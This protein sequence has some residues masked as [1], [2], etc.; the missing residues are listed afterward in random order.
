MATR[1]ILTLN[2]LDEYL[3]KIAQA[4]KDVD[5]AAAHAV[6][7][8]GD[9]LVEGTRKRVAVLTGDLKAHLN[10]TK[11]VQNGNFTYVEVGVFDGENLPDAALARKANAQEYGTASMPAHPYLR[12][13]IDEDKGKVHA[14]E[15]AA[16]KKDGIL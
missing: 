1:A 15:R 6:V 4:G 16:L 7:A 5:V 2:G 3:E 11:P 8:G 13:A 12:P 14:A 9:V 10:R